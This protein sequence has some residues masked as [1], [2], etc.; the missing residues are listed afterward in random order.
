ME[1]DS[2][3]N[4]LKSKDKKIRYRALDKILEFSRSNKTLWKK[5]FLNTVLLK[6]ASKDWEERYLA[7][8]AIS[9]FMRK[10]WD[11]EDFKIQFLNIVLLLEDV[12]GRVRIAA[13][14]AL[15]HF[16]TSFLFYGWGEWKVDENKLL[17][18][19]KSSLFS[20]GAKVI[21]MN[22]G[23]MQAHMVQCVKILFQNDLEDCLNTSDHKKYETLWNKIN[24]LDEM[25]YE[26]GV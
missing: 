8:Y 2:I 19:W 11:F 3:F 5:D 10:N 17:L 22:N 14:N 26:Y 20:L 9:R 1:V 25:Y 23:K 24:E 15:E 12:D 18:L 4:A 13:R 21:N 7:M 16:R 6:S